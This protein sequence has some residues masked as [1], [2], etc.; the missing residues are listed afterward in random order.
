MKTSNRYYLR[1]ILIA[2]V[3]F[4]ALIVMQVNWLLQAIDIQKEETHN[5]LLN[6]V[7]DIALAFNATNPQALHG[8]TVQL[9]KLDQ[10]KLDYLLDSVLNAHQLSLELAY[11][12]Y[13]DSIS[14][15]FSSNIPEYKEEL[16][17]SDIRSCI[18]CI[19][20]F[21][22]IEDGKQ[23]ENESDEE[24]E[25]R[26][27]EEA[28]FQYFS[29]IENPMNKE[30]SVVWVS[31]YLPNATSQALQALIVLF[32]INVVLI[33][34]LLALFYY[35]LRSFQKHKQLSQ[36]K[37]DFF[38]NMTHEF[39]T[40]LSSIRLA[41]KVLK[42]SDDL[43]PNKKYIYHQLIE[44]E[45][46]R[47]EKQVDQLLQLSLIDQ[48]ELELV[49]KPIQL[50]NMLNEIP[51]RLKVLLDQ[52]QAELTIDSELDE[53]T[54]QGDYQHLLNSIC[55]LVE[56][57]IKYS[58]EKVKIFIIAY[59]KNQKRIIHVRDDGPGID[60]S[61][62]EKVFDRFFRAQKQDQY[63]GKGFGIGLSYVKSIIEAHNGTIQL[64][65]QYKEG[66]E[67]IIEL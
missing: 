7:P 26:L 39:K 11:G 50:E 23:N 19:T 35:L 52:K 63:K 13:E 58:Q 33:F 62:A 9:N 49:A 12:I 57:S 55:N 41:S 29:P 48:K 17:Q 51:E 47:L 34:L 15:A 6:I 43:K 32:C 64:N 24:Y 30:A 67:F 38:N 5:R 65:S 37:D 44:K 56:N 21:Y 61:F 53:T 60:P 45:T 42:Q 28:E 20:S 3:L 4:V 18:S 16:L 1:I 27:F 2:S 46:E 31:L 40:P 66:C 14:H 8:D 59:L 10:T 36:V 22:I 25:E 54:I